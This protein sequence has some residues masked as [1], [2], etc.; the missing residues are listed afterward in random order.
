[1][2]TRTTRTM[3]PTTATTTML[4]TR[5]MIILIASTYHTTVAVKFKQHLRCPVT[6][7]KKG[8][9]LLLRRR[10]GC[11]DRCGCSGL[12]PGCTRRQVFESVPEAG[13]LAAIAPAGT[14]RQTAPAADLLRAQRWPRKGRTPR[15]ECHRVISCE[16]AHDGSVSVVSR[17]RVCLQK[18]PVDC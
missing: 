12:R 17:K 1:M 11:N 3:T 2:T 4:M 5:T 13:T 10:R 14:S 8:W 16:A 6:K 7:T 18:T 15:S 9:H